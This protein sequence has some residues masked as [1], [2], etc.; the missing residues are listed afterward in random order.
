MTSQDRSATPKLEVTKFNLQSFLHVRTTDHS[1]VEESISHKYTSKRTTTKT[2]AS[3]HVPFVCKNPASY[4]SDG[5]EI[6]VRGIVVLDA[7]A[8]TVFEGFDEETT[9]TKP[10]EVLSVSMSQLDS[11]SCKKFRST[12]RN[13]C[14]GRV[15]LVGYMGNDWKER[16][17]LK[18]E[19]EEY[20]R[21]KEALKSWSGQT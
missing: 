20:R 5:F 21:F 13:Y 16:L 17:V 3:F 11:I 4:G 12:G 15:E 9:S 14:G 1:I 19:L 6:C 10:N 8:L 18:M 7:D 2:M